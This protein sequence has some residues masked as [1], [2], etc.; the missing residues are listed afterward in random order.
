MIAITKGGSR[1]G[2]PVALEMGG[3]PLP[4]G[5][6]G[7]GG[8]GGGGSI[9]RVRARV[10]VGVGVGVRFGVPMPSREPSSR[11]IA[12]KAESSARGSVPPVVSY[13]GWG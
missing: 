3:V 12:Q 10:R 1:A 2:S 6:W 7:G 4:G 8:G 13:L 11:I 9:I 5:G